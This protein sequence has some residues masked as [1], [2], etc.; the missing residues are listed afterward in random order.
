MIDPKRFGYYKV[1]NL[2]VYSKI[3]ALEIS[4]RLKETI[5]WH[6]NDEVFDTVDWTKEPADSLEE[7]YKARARQ[8]RSEYD[9]VVVFYSGGADSH[10]MLE[11]FIN[12]G[13]HIDEIVSF[14]S[15]SADGDRNSEFNREIY[16]TAIPFVESLRSDNRL[17]S[18]TPHRLIDMAE[19]I[20]KF[21]Q[22]ID[23]LDFPYMVSSAFSINNVA[24]SNLRKYVKEWQDLILQGKKLV[25]VWGHD[26]PRV[27]HE[28]GK[29]YLQ[30]MDIFDNC[31]STR[32][33]QSTI[34]GWYDEMF[35][36]TPDMPELI[37]KQ[38]HVIKKFLENCKPDHPWMSESV[39]GL[40]HT[41]K[42]QSDGSWKSIWLSQDG[43]SFL[44]YP[45]FRPDLYY[46]SKPLDIIFS[47]RDRWFWSDKII[48]ARYKN[49]IDGLV[50]SF[51]DKWLRQDPT[52]GIRSTINFRS[53][54]YW[55]DRPVDQ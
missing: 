38:A 15:L 32:L 16:Q 28:D 11:S 29:H 6:Y 37:V 47:K 44:V 53:K 55:L 3:E 36:S 25:L 33:Q 45:W 51:G 40:G 10:N 9:Y 7:I 20:T 5:S 54:K 8:L 22:D 39:T 14:H 26:K 50:S 48:G 41:V 49:I 21:C 24:R 12:A 2:Q 42:H 34:P 43:Q 17:S 30:F 19:I 23:W 46:E 4:Q 35:Y 52:R 13:V 27:M 31:V 1:G 18:T